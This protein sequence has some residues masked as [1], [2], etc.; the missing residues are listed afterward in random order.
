MTRYLVSITPRGRPRDTASAWV[1]AACDDDAYARAVRACYGDDARFRPDPARDAGIGHIVRAAHARDEV[2]VD[3]V[4]LFAV[5]LPDDPCGP[6]E[7]LFR[8]VLATCVGVLGALVEHP[9]PYD[10]ARLFPTSP[11]PQGDTPTMRLW[12]NNPDTPEGKYPIVLRRD[13]TPVETP[14]MVLLVKDPAFDAAIRAYA[15]EGERLGYDPAYI[16]DLRALVAEAPAIRAAL[17]A[18]GSPPPDPDAPRHRPDDPVTLAW[19]R[20]LHCPGR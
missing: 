7:T 17:A 4:S 16:A 14:Y 18:A 6:F 13:G 8:G 1:E 2:I 9:G 5:K 15:D 20:S 3:A 10:L 12:R 11:A 19:A